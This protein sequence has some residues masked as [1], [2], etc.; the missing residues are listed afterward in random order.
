[1]SRVGGKAQVPALRALSGRLRLDYAQFLELEM[2]SRLGGLSDARLSAQIAR[3]GAIRALPTQPRLAVLRLGDQAA[4]L[5]ALAD[6]ALDGKRPEALEALRARLPARLDAEASDVLTAVEAG[7][8]L[9][10]Q[11]RARLSA[12]VRR[13]LDEAGA[14]E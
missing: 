6:G 11:A 3:G 4:L 8:R 10:D 2:F 7:E 13:L 9:D 12:L 5:A 1:M 14:G